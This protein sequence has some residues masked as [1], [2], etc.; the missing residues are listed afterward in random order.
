[1]ATAARPP[2]TRNMIAPIVQSIVD[3]DGSSVIEMAEGSVASVAAAIGVA[4]GFGVCKISCSG[5]EETG[6]TEAMGVRDPATFGSGARTT[7]GRSKSV[8]AGADRS[9]ASSR[10]AGPRSTFARSARRSDL[11]CRSTHAW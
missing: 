11:N 2:M 6:F 3:E 4:G 5:A 7:D 10:L 1:M 9:A 8:E